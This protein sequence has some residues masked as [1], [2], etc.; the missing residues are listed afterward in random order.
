V[1]RADWL[2]E[3]IE[4]ACGDL[5]RHRIREHSDPSARLGNLDEGSDK[6]KKPPGIPP[7]EAGKILRE[8]KEK[9]YA[10]WT[11]SP[12]PALDGRTPREAVRTKEGKSRV[13]LLLKECENHEARLPKDEQFDFSSIRKK[14]GL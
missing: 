12:L 9:H 2:R 14:L 8:Y 5:I 10:E 6:A 4:A 7:P 3:R 1:N 13:D 11:D